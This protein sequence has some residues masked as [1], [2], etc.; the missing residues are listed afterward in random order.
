MRVG[1]AGHQVQRSGP[2]RGNADPGAAG[3]PPVRRRHERRRLLVPR[4]HELDARIAQGLDD[5]EIFLAGHPEDVL[6][7]LV[8]QRCHQQV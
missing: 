4:E 5:V 2:E 8:L 1:R 6:D 3:Q 7:A